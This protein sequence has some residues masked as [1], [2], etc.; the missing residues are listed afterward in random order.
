M[1]TTLE[2]KIIASIQGDL[3]VVPRPYKAI[4][5]T[6]GVTENEVIQ[7]LYHL[8]EQ[9]IIRRFGA[10]LRHQK[11]GYEANAMGAW[12]VPEE[13]V[14][15]VGE[16]MAGFREVSHCYRRDPAKDWPYNVYTMIHARSEDACREIARRISK[17]TGIDAYDL[18]FSVRELKK[19]TMKYFSSRG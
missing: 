8:C 10:T 7:A 12:R 18:L 15:T 11:S 14:E 2:K 6:L 5:E 4:A 1:L 17:K 19:T 16:I 3:P 9:G 13:R